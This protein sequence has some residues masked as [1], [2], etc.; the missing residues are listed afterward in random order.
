[1]SLTKTEGV[2]P[3]QVYSVVASYFVMDIDEKG[4]PIETRLENQKIELF[5]FMRRNVEH[6]KFCLDILYGRVSEED[7]ARRFIEL[8]CVDDKIKEVLLGDVL[9]CIEIFG[10]EKVQEELRDFF[11]KWDLFKKAISQKLSTKE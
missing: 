8:C 6:G 3:S 1:M 5:R 10:N 2:N 4:L 7:I 9:A 11:D